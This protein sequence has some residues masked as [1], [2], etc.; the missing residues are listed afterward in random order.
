MYR[1]LRQERQFAHRRSERSAPKRSKPL[2]LAANGSDQV[3][4]WDITY[5]PT[6]VR[7]QHFY[8]YLFEGV[9]P[10]STG[11]LV[12]HCF[13]ASIGNYQPY[14]AVRNNLTTPQ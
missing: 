14:R 7:G 12:I 9:R 11:Q 3:F 8:V 10:G 1:L 2:A 13:R 4:C 5:W 6:Q